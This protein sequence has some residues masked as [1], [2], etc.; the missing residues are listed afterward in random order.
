MSRR[1]RPRSQPNGAHFS[2]LGV[3]SATRE[4]PSREPGGE[5]DAEDVEEGRV[6]EVEPVLEERVPEHGLGEV[7]LEGE[8]RRPD[9]EDDEAVEDQEGPGARATRAGRGPARG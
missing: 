4:A 8:D 5:R 7:V 9:E 1:P 3:S 6:A 2:K